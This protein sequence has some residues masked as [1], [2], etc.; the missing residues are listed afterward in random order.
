M[1]GYKTIVVTKE[2][3][4]KLDKLKVHHREPYWEVI[5]RLI[6]KCAEK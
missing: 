1:T 4:E 6:D 2:I 3:K 5:K